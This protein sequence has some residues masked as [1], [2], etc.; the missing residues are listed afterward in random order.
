[1]IY[2]NKP[3]FSK[4]ATIFITATINFKADSIHY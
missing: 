2:I 4:H 3:R 1:M